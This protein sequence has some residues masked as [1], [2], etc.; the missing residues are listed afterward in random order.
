MSLPR[1]LRVATPLGVHPE[2]A[3]GRGAW[4][5]N[6]WDLSRKRTFQANYWY[7]I[8]F[9]NWFKLP[10]LSGSVSVWHFPLI[11]LV[12]GSILMPGFFLVGYQKTYNTLFQVFLTLTTHLKLLCLYFPARNDTLFNYKSCMNAYEGR[13][14]LRYWTC[15]PKF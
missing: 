9:F 10:W 5:Y 1:T 7:I 14:S 8:H 13:L 2:T 15:L 3:T 12:P 6:P 11:F 4:L